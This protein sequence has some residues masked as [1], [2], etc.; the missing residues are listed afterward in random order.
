MKRIITIVYL[1]GFATIL[2]SCVQKTKE[3]T[4]IFE[5]DMKA[6]TNVKT[7]HAIIDVL[8]QDSQRIELKDEDL[9]AIYIGKIVLN[10]PFDELKT[11]FVKNGSEVE[12]SD[13]DSRV[14]KFRESGKTVYTA[15]FN[16]L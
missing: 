11:K 2:Q 6:E 16:E 4:V 15:V 14:V 8:S 5:V 9:D 3:Q 1:I 10:I 13:K 12:L 7:V